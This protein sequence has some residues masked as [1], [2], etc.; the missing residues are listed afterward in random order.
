[1]VYGKG[2]VRHS[3]LHSAADSKLVGVDFRTQAA[4]RSRFQDAGRVF[5]GEE[6]RVAEHVHEV[7]K[8][9]GAWH[10]ID[11][12]F[13][14]LLPAQAAGHGVGAEESRADEGAAILAKPFYDAQHLHL[15]ILAEPV[16]ALDFNGSGAE[17]HH[18]PHPDKG[19]PIEL[20]FGRRSQQVGGV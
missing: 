4:A 13:D 17:G 1:M 6:A 15:A 11:Y 14:V 12:L 5:G 20:V 18:L 3:H 8:L 19:L 16:S 9:R 10:H 2:S 7:G